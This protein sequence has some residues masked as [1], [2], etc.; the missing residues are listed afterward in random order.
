MSS[1]E[2]KRLSD[3]VETMAPEGHNDGRWFLLEH[4]LYES[5]F[6]LQV[7]RLQMETIG[8][9]PENE[10]EREL[11]GDVLDILTPAFTQVLGALAS[12]KSLLAGTETAERIGG[13]ENEQPG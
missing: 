7:A 12:V 1:P 6:A 13:K 11:A 4:Q 3:V 2:A 5:K 10:Q 9:F 8:D